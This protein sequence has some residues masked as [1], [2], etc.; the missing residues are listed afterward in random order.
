M[1]EHRPQEQAQTSGSYDAAQAGRD[2]N[3]A[4]VLLDHLAR[5]C[6]RYRQSRDW[7]PILLWMAEEVRRQS[8]ALRV[9]GETSRRM[10]EQA[11][12]AQTLVLRASA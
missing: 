2:E 3:Y 12:Q 7:G 5:D 6:D 10:R 8:G 11:H 4:R 1:S 9:P